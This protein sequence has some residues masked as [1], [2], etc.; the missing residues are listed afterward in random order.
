MLNRERERFKYALGE[1]EWYLEPTSMIYVRGKVI[2]GTYK[3]TLGM[4][5]SDVKS[6]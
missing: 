6:L 3:Y 4:G 5:K 1:K 2:S